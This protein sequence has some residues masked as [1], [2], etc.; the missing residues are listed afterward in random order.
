MLSLRDTNNPSYLSEIMSL[1]GKIQNWNVRF[2][3]WPSTYFYC[4]PEDSMFPADV[5]INLRHILKIFPASWEG[6]KSNLTLSLLWDREGYF[7]AWRS[8]WKA[9]WTFWRGS[10]STIG[11]E[12]SWASPVVTSPVTRVCFSIVHAAGTPTALS[13]DPH[14]SHKE[15]NHGKASLF[16]VTGK[17]NS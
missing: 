12:W 6:M 11:A 14:E 7:Q 4:L 1:A 8:M 9:P 16:A 17:R 2:W 15:E 5:S 3:V 13:C 10:K